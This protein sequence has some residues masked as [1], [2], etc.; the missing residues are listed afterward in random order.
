LFSTVIGIHAL[1]HL[2]LEQQYD[3]IPFNLWEINTTD[4]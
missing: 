4:D 3:Y 2:G 1:S